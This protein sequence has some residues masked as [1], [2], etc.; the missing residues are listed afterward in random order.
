MPE[1]CAGSR[2]ARDAMK[3]RY[4]AR[5]KDGKTQA[6]TIEASS[7]DAALELL[8]SHGLFVTLLERAD[9]VPVWAREIELFNRVNMRDIMVFFR[10]LSVMFASQVPLIEALRTLANQ[11]QNESFREK[12]YKI[13][14]SVEGGTPL[15]SAMEA[16]PQIFSGFSVSMVKSGEAS[17][18]LSEVLAYLADHIER[19]YALLSKVRGALVYPIFVVAVSILVLVFLLTFVIPNLT[20]VLEASGQELP[21]MTRLVIGTSNAARSWGWAV[22]VLLAGFGFYAWQAYKTEEGRQKAGKLILRIPLLGGLLRK[23]YVVRFAESISTLISSGLP[24]TQAL[25]ITAEVLGN[26]AYQDILEEAKDAVRGG[27]RIS[28]VLQRHSKE[29]PPVITQMI[30]VG[31][32][33]GTLGTVLESVV[34]FY[35]QETERSIANLVNILEPALIIFLGVVVGGIMAS[36][37]LPI[38]QMASF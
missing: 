36:I 17:G 23:V 35:R 1:N 8:G 10:Q 13:S 5:D 19:E 15:S 2:G 22:L 33:T 28:T 9:E 30:A 32:R 24:I 11:E 14:E 12:I 20:R 26:R 27:A 37:L 6:G 16:Y 4:Q 38:Y 31:E 21:L 34:N 7:N 25:D 29:F 18:K 3:F